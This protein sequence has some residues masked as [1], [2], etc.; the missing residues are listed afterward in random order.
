MRDIVSW[1]ITPSHAVLETSEAHICVKTVLEAG[2]LPHPMRSS[3]GL[4]GLVVDKSMGADKPSKGDRIAESISVGQ[5]NQED[6]KYG[7]QS[8]KSRK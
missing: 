4:F 6:T 5:D 3:H 1:H 8:V 7:M 2:T